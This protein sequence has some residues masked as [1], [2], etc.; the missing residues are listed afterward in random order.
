M[1]RLLLLLFIP[2]ISFGQINVSQPDGWFNQIDES[3]DFRYKNLELVVGKDGAL[4]IKNFDKFK[5]HNFLISSTKYDIKFHTGIS[6]TIN[7]VAIKNNEG[8]VFEDFQ[9]YVQVLLAELENAG[10]KE[11][12]LTDSKAVKLK[13]GKEAFK[14]QVEYKLPNYSDKVILTNYSYFITKKMYVQLSLLGLENDRC[15]EIFK[16]VLNQL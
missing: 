12:K 13:S 6:P 14:F 8:F 9:K 4:V 16:Q 15:T 5:D 7:L 1:K 11:I 10:I 2:L 3:D